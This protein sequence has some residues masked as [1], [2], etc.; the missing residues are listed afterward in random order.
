MEEKVKYG[1]QVF[2]L[3]DLKYK[4]KL[5]RMVNKD[6]QSRGHRAP[7]IQL[8]KIRITRLDGSLNC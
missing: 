8:F 6:K 1:Q 5:E 3:T 7:L 2:Q 4:D